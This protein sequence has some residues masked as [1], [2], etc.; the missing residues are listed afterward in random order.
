MISARGWLRYW[1]QGTE[2]EMAQLLGRE[3][4]TVEPAAARG[5]RPLRELAGPQ[6]A[7]A[8]ASKMTQP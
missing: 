8:P 2:A 4:G 7:P 5:L 6:P 3:E 1:E